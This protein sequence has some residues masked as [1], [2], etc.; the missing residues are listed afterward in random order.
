MNTFKLKVLPATMLTMG[1]VLSAQSLAAESAL[2][3]KSETQPQANQSVHPE[4]NKKT[5]DAAAE[6]NQQLIA[7]ARTA[8]AETE[9]ALQALKENK[10]KEAL[11]ALA[12]ATGKLELVLARNPKLVLAPVNTVVVTQDLV[13][14][15]D[16]ANAV[17]KQAKEYLSDGEIQ[18]ARPLVANLAS[19]IQYRT[20]NVPLETY[21]KAIKAIVPL[22]D[23][24]KIDEAKAGLQ[25]TLNT[26]VIT[27][28]VVPLPKVRAEQLLKEAQ[29]LAEKK[30]RSK[31]E[32][33]KIAKYVQSSREQL[34]MA[35]LLGYGNRKDYK[36][37]YEQ[38]DEIAKKSGDG[39]SVIGWFD[40]IKKQLS[41]LI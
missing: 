2:P 19:E 41:D 23:A 25:A 34:E 39:K 16:R 36:P 12:V 30:D 9:K 1:L 7:D 37:M 33:D 6:Q 14:N 17:F 4:A 31:E 10:K 28:E 11:D 24:G 32:N 20:T 3:K 22:I 15:R 29:S 13:T 26:V 8:I 38:L 18:K 27:T 21:P 5:A 35:E 40:K